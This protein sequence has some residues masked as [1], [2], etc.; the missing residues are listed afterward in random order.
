MRSA[1]IWKKNMQAVILRS[2][3]KM[4][5]LPELFEEVSK[6]SVRPVTR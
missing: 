6:L 5:G 1:F 4:N 3:K 2:L